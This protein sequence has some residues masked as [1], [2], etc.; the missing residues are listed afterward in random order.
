MAGK[1]KPEDLP[2][3]TVMRC[4]ATG[5]YFSLNNRRLWVLKQCR[6]LGLLNVIRVRV[7]TEE[8]KYSTDT[9]SLTAKVCLK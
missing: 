2:F 5:H 7:R 6:E 8:S 4:S 1:L 3:I 9:C